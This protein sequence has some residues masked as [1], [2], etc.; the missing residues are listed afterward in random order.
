[1]PLG[2]NMLGQDRE[3]LNGRGVGIGMLDTSAVQPY[4]LHLGRRGMHG[5]VVQ[6]TG[7]SP[8]SPSEYLSEG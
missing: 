1:M 2:V 8:L 4:K 6:P 5:V 3:V 7:F